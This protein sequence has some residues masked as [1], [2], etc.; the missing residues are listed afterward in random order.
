M[1]P[2]LLTAD[3]AEIYY[4]DWGTGRPVVFSHGWPLNADAWD[5]QMDLVASAGYRGVAYDRRGHGRSSQTWDGNTMD[6]YADD[7]AELIEILEMTDA[8]LVGHCAGGGE[9]VR[10]LARHGTSRVSGAV[11]LGAVT[12]YLLRTDDNPSGV[13]GEAF[14]LLRSGVSTDRSQFYKDLAILFYSANRHGSTVSQGALD[15]F[16]LRSMQAGVKPALASIAA[17][18]E[19][20]FRKDLATIDVPVLVVHCEDDQI[21]PFHAAG[22]LTAGRLPNATLQVHPGGSHG[23]VGGLEAVFNQ[24]LLD[25]IS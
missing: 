6:Q 17:F 3:G 4:K 1:M 16:W 11:L 24:E 5:S 7:L 22:P 18:A 8:V 13:P 20:D 2:R 21:V 12:P 9:V 15:A 14:D 10:Y 25:F 19:T 23:L